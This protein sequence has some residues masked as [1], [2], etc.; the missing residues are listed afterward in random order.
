MLTAIFSACA[1]RSRIIEVRLA[2]T[3]ALSNAMCRRAELRAAARARPHHAGDVRVRDVPDVRV[4]QAAYEVLVGVAENYYD[5]L[6]VHH[7]HVQ[8][9][10]DHQG[11]RGGGCAAGDRILGR[12]VRG[13]DREEL[14]EGANP[15][16]Y[17]RFVEQA[18]D[19]ARCSW[20]RSPAGRD[21]VE[22]GGGGRRDGR[23][24]LRSRRDVRQRSGGGRGDAVHHRQ[25]HP[26]RPVAPSRA[27]CTPSAACGRT[28]RR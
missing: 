25:H 27:A 4:Q 6:A 15:P 8:P 14:Q 19:N 16:A 18:S 5:K 9:D 26:T 7:R 3:V 24:D 10:H 12:R 23:R 20:R 13:G 28:R 17:H 1:R 21:Q 11:G 2:A 22:D